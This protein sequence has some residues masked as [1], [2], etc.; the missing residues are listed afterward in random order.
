MQGGL[1]IECRSRTSCT[2]TMSGFFI[3]AADACLSCVFHK[4]NSL[5]GVKS[6]ER[7]II[8]PATP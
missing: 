5:H 7:K 1:K 6:H 3:N 2:S 8:K 4:K